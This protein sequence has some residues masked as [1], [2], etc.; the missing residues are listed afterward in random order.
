M[1]SEQEVSVKTDSRPYNFLPLCCVSKRPHEV[2]FAGC[3]VQPLPRFPGEENQHGS[4][5]SRPQWGKRPSGGR[6]IQRLEPRR[7]QSSLVRLCALLPMVIHPQTGFVDVGVK[8]SVLLTAL[9][10]SHI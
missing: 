5:V 9:L 2:A 10:V 7:S 1:W 3:R 4:W 6:G 8:V